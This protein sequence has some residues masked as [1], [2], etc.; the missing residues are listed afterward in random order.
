M[1]Q[2]NARRLRRSVDGQD[3]ERGV[4]RS[5]KFTVDY[6]LMVR[7]IVW[8][9]MAWTLETRAVR[10]ALRKLFN[11]AIMLTCRAYGISYVIP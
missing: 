6:R 1:Q 3:C 8:H 5:A 10:L 11:R 4:R 9:G 2:A 7:R